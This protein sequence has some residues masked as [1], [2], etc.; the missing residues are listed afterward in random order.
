MGGVFNNQIPIWRFVFSLMICTLHYWGNDTITVYTRGFYIGV[1]FFFIVSGY[2]MALQ[3]NRG[4][5][6][7]QWMKSHLKK[8]VPY[9]IVMFLLNIMIICRLNNCCKLIFN[10]WPEIIMIHMSGIFSS[11][12]L[13]NAPG[14]YVSALLIS[15]YLLLALLN[16]CKWIVDRVIA[17]IV[18]FVV[19]GYF[20]QLYGTI[21]NWADYMFFT[22]SGTIRAFSG[23]CVGIN[24]YN[25]TSLW[26]PNRFRFRNW[27]TL[28]CFGACI[29]ASFFVAHSSLDFLLII[30]IS[31]GVFFAFAEN[32]KFSRLT[33]IAGF[34]GKVSFPMFLA[35]FWVI[36]VVSFICK[37]L[38]V[39]M[40][41]PT[42]FIIFLFITFV[43]SIFSYYIID[44]SAERLYRRVH[45]IPKEVLKS[46]F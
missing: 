40:Y 12:N 35:H 23:L 46:G 33:M 13:V 19:Y 39:N 14:W 24:L 25:L 9:Y 16:H 6:E 17:P 38:E 44:T 31:I 21:D 7:C 8:M 34:L 30:L 5:T 26:N 32:N 37:I 18:P 41:S 2:I 10:A 22:M 15:G 43:F 4:M 3:T 36:K 42:V 27:L 11:I 45:L 1:E 28:F 29:I 20:Y